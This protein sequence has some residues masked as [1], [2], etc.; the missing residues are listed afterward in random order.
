[1]PSVDALHDDVVYYRVRTGDQN[2][3]VTMAWSPGSAPAPSPSPTRPGPRVA[4]ALAGG[5]GSY[6]VTGTEGTPLTDTGIR[7]GPH[8]APGGR[9]L[10]D[11]QHHPA[12]LS[13]VEVRGD[14]VGASLVWPIPE[15]CAT[16]WGGNRRPVWED[17]DHLLLVT[18]HGTIPDTRVIRVDVTT[19]AIERVN[20]DRPDGTQYDVEVFVE[21]F[22]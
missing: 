5:P 4:A 3:R 10:Y 11:F 2:K 22:R 14:V 17:D 20:I 21:P 18:P 16:A 9:W 15:G 19:G 1:M 8:L 13:V 7:F 6:V 12:T